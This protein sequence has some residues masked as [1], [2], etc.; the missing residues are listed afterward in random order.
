LGAVG[1]DCAVAGVADDDEDDVDA[2]GLAPALIG[3]A[4]LLW[5]CCPDFSDAAGLCGLS[6]TLFALEASF[7]CCFLT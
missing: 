7:S 5:I 1:N 2:D 3:R 4:G 6:T